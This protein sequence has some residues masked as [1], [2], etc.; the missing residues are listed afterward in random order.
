MARLR[1]QWRDSQ[2]AVVVNTIDSEISLTDL[3]SPYPTIYF[4]MYGEETTANRL[5]T[6]LMVLANE[7]VGS[8]GELL[9]VN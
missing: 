3:M 9:Q 6:E 5:V 1:Q 2:G 4:K 8:I 7:A